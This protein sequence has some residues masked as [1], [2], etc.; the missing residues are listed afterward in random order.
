MNADDICVNIKR[1]EILDFSDNRFNNSRIIAF[2]DSWSPP[3]IYDTNTSVCGP[4]AKIAEQ[5]SKLYG[6]RY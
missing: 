1:N 5:L 2:V 4:L 3:F 6:Y